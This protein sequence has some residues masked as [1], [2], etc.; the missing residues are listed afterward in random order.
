MAA[1]ELTPQN[2]SARVVTD[3]TFTAAETDGMY[4]SNDG[5]CYLF[6]R[7]DDVASKDVVTVCQGCSHGLSQNKTYSTGAD[8]ITIVGPFDK[9]VWNDSN[10][11]TN[12]TIAVGT[13]LS[14]AVVRF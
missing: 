13:N 1:V 5:N 2:F 8:D 4:F 3:V 6:I 9:S 12:M 14:L 7:N 11:R 10:G